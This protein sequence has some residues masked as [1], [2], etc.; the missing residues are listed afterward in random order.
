[1]PKFCN[2][3]NTITH[4]PSQLCFTNFVPFKL[5]TILCSRFG[6]FNAQA[7]SCVSLCFLSISIRIYLCISLL[8]PVIMHCLHKRSS[9]YMH[10]LCY[11]CQSFPRAIY[12]TYAGAS[13][14][15]LHIQRPIPSRTSYFLGTKT[16]QNFLTSLV[17]RH[18]SSCYLN[19]LQSRG[20][21]Q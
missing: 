1:M 20:I 6:F 18:S 21:H 5:K 17:Q 9:V 8:S 12:F 10:Y 3:P 2:K 4:T 7:L 13:Q 15:T 11:I 16:Q 19:K 14:S